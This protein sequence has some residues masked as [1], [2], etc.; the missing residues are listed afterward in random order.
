LMWL[1]ERRDSAHIS[2]VLLNLLTNAMDAVQCR[3]QNVRRVRVE[4]R[5]D[6]NRCSDGGGSGLGAGNS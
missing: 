1:F 5:A 3:P 4:A 6:E 2:Q